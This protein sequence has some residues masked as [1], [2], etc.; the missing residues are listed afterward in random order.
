MKAAV[1]VSLL[2]ALAHTV[3][4]KAVHLAQA[5]DVLVPEYPE[6]YTIEATF[7]IPYA[8]L[9]EPVQVWTDRTNHRQAV[10]F[11]D[12]LD[13]Y[14]YH[15]VGTPNGTSY[16]LYVAKDRK[17]C[18]KFPLKE[19]FRNSTN[20]VYPVAFLPDLTLFTY[21]GV[22][23]CKPFYQGSCHRW[24]YQ[25]KKYEMLNHYEFY[26]R[27]DSAFTPV[28]Y[29]MVGYDLPFASHY[30][31]YKIEYI[32]FTPKVDPAHFD[33]PDYCALAN[34][35]RGAHH[36]S[37]LEDF[38]GLFGSVD[39]VREKF[40]DFM[41]KHKKDYEV[42]TEE[43]RKRHMNFRKNHAIINNMNKKSSSVT[44]A[45][46][47]LADHSKEE[48]KR[49]NGYVPLDAAGWNNLAANGDIEI[50]YHN[51]PGKDLPASIDWR[52]SGAVS[53]VKDQ[54]KCGSCWAFGVAQVVESAWFQKKGALLV[55]S[56][57][58]LIDCAWDEGP[59]GCDGGS[60]VAAMTYIKKAGGLMRENEYKYTGE[61]GYCMF[62]QEDAA[63]QIDKVVR[64]SVGDEEGMKDALA[65]VGP[66]AV[67][68]DASQE[69]FTFYSS[70]V[71]YDPNCTKVLDHAVVAVGYGT[72]SEG[73]DF[74]LV[75][76]SWSTYWGEMGYFRIARNRDNH[77]GI[78]SEVAYPVIA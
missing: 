8:E 13:G 28:Y 26:A 63:V 67:A 56:E 9:S 44:Y 21:Q 11:Y 42:D 70:G 69:S 16:E 61:N 7:H 45:I 27:N 2:G 51:K 37:I 5:N 40:H 35:D 14:V 52:H 74:W 32:S 62:K 57:Q 47:H 33:L 54:G 39:H 71:Y 41:D 18:R 30:D 4:G 19:K 1:G 78:A 66:L 43:Y 50:V 58:Q 65:N 73:E 34:E 12:G 36:Q 22:D 17:K 55:L 49:F 29:T 76:N 46:N 60:P 64:V 72:T 15:G 77:C 48:L 23:N 31:M 25:Y 53:Q 6:Q 24:T 75:K 10:S 59:Q 68:F 3:A 38:G 20:K